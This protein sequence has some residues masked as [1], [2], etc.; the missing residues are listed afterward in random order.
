MDVTII[1]QTTMVTLCWVHWQAAHKT[2]LPPISYGLCTSLLLNLLSMIPRFTE[3]P[4]ASSLSSIPIIL[5]LLYV[6]WQALPAWKGHKD[7][8]LCYLA[9]LLIAVCMW[10]APGVAAGLLIFCLA[11]HRQN[12][13]LMALS[14]A[15]LVLFGAY[16]YYNLELTLLYKSL[17]LIIS[18][19]LTIIIR[20]AAL[21]LQIKTR[22]IDA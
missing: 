21:H 4:Y 6:A 1:I 8:W 20:S 19:I 18:G 2:W 10:K 15:Y 9:I 16:F 12:N 7:I 22:Q 13:I 11:I 17:W 5:A 3:L 14:I